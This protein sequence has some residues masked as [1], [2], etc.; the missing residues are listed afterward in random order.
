LEDAG[1]RNEH[2]ADVGVDGIGISSEHVELD[3]A[4]TFGCLGIAD[5]RPADSHSR[6]DVIGAEPACD[7][8]FGEPSLGWWGWPRKHDRPAA[9]TLDC[10]ATYRL[11]S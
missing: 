2:V 10:A 1:T 5:G 6:R 4:V 7:T 3:R 11:N 9:M 8:N